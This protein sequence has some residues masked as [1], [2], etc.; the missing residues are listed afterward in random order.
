MRPSCRILFIIRSDIWC[1]TDVSLPVVM[2]AERLPRGEL[3]AVALELH[4]RRMIWKGTMPTHP[5][6]FLDNATPTVTQG[7]DEDL[8]SYGIVTNFSPSM[9]PSLFTATGLEVQSW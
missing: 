5:L 8:R 3:T 7:G 9:D 2:F 4:I 1:P 6:Y